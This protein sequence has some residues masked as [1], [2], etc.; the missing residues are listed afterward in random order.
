[1][2]DEKGGGGVGVGGGGFFRLPLGTTCSFLASSFRGGI[3]G[4]A[5]LISSLD[6]ST[7]IDA[8]NSFPLLRVMAFQCSFPSLL[9]LNSKALGKKPCGLSFVMLD[10][11]PNRT[12]IFRI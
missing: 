4:R 5:S 3:E 6:F 12:S 11:C 9:G 10:I 8:F 1:M 2:D 7:S